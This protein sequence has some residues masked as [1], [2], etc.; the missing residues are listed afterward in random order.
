MEKKWIIHQLERKSDNGFVFNVHWR[1]SI[2]EIDES[3]KQYYADSYSVASYTQDEES[4]DYIP[5]EDLTEE[6]VIGWVKSSIGEEQLDNMEA[7]LLQQIEN[8]K[9]PPTLSGVPWLTTTNETII[10]DINE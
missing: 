9:T 8:Q 5:Y 7:S 2:T 6:I 3:G 4:D 1:Y 10:E